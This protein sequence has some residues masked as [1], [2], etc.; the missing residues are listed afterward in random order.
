MYHDLK[1]VLWLE[2]F[3]KDIAEF[4]SKCPPN[5]QVKDGHQ[6]PGFLL[7]EIQVATWEWKDIN[8][9]FVV[10]LPWSQKQY[11]SMWVSMNRMTK[12]SHFIP[13]KSTY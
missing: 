2:V 4:F 6:N 13:V 12:F 5:Q 9:D 8:M 7:Q 11:D 1:E 10:G 3:K